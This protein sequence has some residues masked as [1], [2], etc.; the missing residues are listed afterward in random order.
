VA[1]N[2]GKEMT[3]LRQMTVRELQA[4]YLE[5]FGEPTRQHHKQYLIKRIIWRMQANEEG[6]LSERARR[7]AAELASD[8]DLRQYAPRQTQDP[9]APERTK[10][11]PVRFACDNRLPMAG[12]ILTRKYKGQMHEVTVLADGFEYQGKVYRTLSAVA[13]A[14][15]GTHW[16]G[17]HFFRLLKDRKAS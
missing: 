7:R 13:K 14:I 3:V 12:A 9:A 16:N 8:A 6:D 15:T 10:V 11:V 4:K 17:Y 1:L 5:V 2:V